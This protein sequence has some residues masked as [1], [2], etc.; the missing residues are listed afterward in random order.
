MKKILN[1]RYI[2]LCLWVFAAVI[3]T[4]FMP[5]LKAIINERGNATVPENYPSQVAQKMI[6]NI[7][8]TSGNSGILVFTSDTKLTDAQKSEIKNALQNVEADKE[9]LGIT[10]VL[11]CYNTP[12]AESQ[13]VSS[14]DTT[15]LAQF[16]YVKN[17]WGVKTL[18]SYLQNQLKS[19]S[20]THYITG[21]DF[22][23]HDYTDLASQSVAKSGII[24]VIFILIV[25]IVMF[26]SV[27]TPFVSLLS[28]GV[29]YFVSMGIVGQLID[30]FSFPVSVLTQMF[31]ILI[32]F[33]IGTDYNVLLY[34]R[35][36]EELK[37]N[38]SIDDAI[39]ATYRT[40]G[41]T[42]FFSA[43]TVFIA[44]VSLSFVKFGVYQ[45]GVAVAIAIMV[46]ILV[47]TTLTPAMFKIL[48]KALFWPS[49]EATG[50]KKSR[51]WEKVT[52]ISVKH[53][54]FATIAAAL[55]L[56]PM[57][58]I[59]SPRVTFDNLKDMNNSSPS[60]TGYNA[61]SKHFGNGKIMP[62][63]IVIGNDK[64]MDNN[65]DLAVID[66]LTYKIRK[67]KGVANVSGPT[68]PQ[69]AEI[70]EFY[71]GGQIKQTA[72]GLNTA[73][74]GITTI[75]NGLSTMQS[76]IT[77]PDFS[78][79]NQLVSGTATIQ[80]G[81]QSITRALAKIQNGISSGASGGTDIA[82][83]IAKIRTNL[84]TISDTLN[85]LS[86]GYTQLESGY[87][88]FGTNYAA[89]E[90]SLSGLCQLAVELK[91]AV[92][93]NPTFAKIQP[94]VEQLSAGL[95]Q[96]DIGFQTLNSNYN[97]AISNFKTLNGGLAQISSG[98]PQMVA[99][100]EQLEQGQKAL[101]DGLKQGA[102]GQGTIVANMQQ[103]SEGLKD[104]NQGQSQLASGLQTM[105]SSLPQLK[106]ALKQS[107]D[108]LNKIHD[109][110]SQAN[111]YLS[112]LSASDK[113]FYIP[114][115]ALSNSYVQKVFDAYMSKDRK[116]AEIIVTLDSDPYSD[117]AINTVKNIN[118]MI[119]T[120]LNGTTLSNATIVTGG[121]S[122]YTNDL[123]NV[124][125][126]DMNNTQII[127]L[128]AVF[129]L[130]LFVLKSFWTP[131][132]LVGSILLTYNISMALTGFISEKLLHISQ[133]GWNVPFFA[134]IMIVT[135][136]VDYGIFLLTRYREYR[137]LT[138]HEAIIEAS[139]NVGGVVIAAA[140]ILAGTFLTLIPSGMGTLIEMAIVVALGIA[141]LSVV[142]LPF[143]IPACISV[144]DWLKKKYGFR[145]DEKRD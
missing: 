77:T 89:L 40:A 64:P 107:S 26:R 88:T 63:N 34:N 70:P 85:Q 116:T 79:V 51:L 81:M 62:T 124:A 142:F 27:I 66:S 93:S 16:T 50:H 119:E 126:S 121:I 67:M 17:A 123:H 90:N 109:G 78:Q 11:D 76:K 5:N 33:G 105:G 96:I 35:F 37:K 128:I 134:F 31:I 80:T 82:N 28:I 39:V 54:Y 125:T 43:I 84:S 12:E 69:G 56:L 102:G 111:D 61:V 137:T 94:Q 95:S 48:G 72:S 21:N 58:L 104:I 46:L 52:A 65:A 6:D 110:I 32:L 23:L 15:M 98:L 29:S 113:S 130:L 144:E 131:L 25:L 44:F 141:I 92:D 115:Q 41:K 53:P 18:Q 114:D 91:Q 145:L 83:G 112:T 47:L 138:S 30:K 117:Q 101:A 106:D 59:G 49:K 7:T 42:F 73:N 143:I 97:A 13:L 2:I 103:M 10:K 22:I 133:L 140:V 118:S 55:V 36:K 24:T 108:G 9:T 139:A 14:D 136:G 57:L 3:L 19:V 122:A 135:L 100:L 86:S 60:V 4:Y 45:S 127:V 99:G 1:S 71:S 20:V 87:E 129:I 68:Q 120:S 75:S 38:S 132:Y 8:A 74:D